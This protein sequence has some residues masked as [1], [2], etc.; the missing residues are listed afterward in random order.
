MPLLSTFGAASARSFGGIGGAAAGAGLD[1]TDAFSTFLYQGTGS[2]QSINNGI[3]LSG[4]GGLVWI[5][6]NQSRAHALFDTERGV[7]KVLITAETAAQANTANALTAFNSNGFSLGIDD[8]DLVNKNSS[9]NRMVAWTFRKA[10]KFF[11]VVTYTGN[12]SSRTISHNLGSVPGMIIIK[13]TTS[14]ED[15]VVY[16]RSLG[17]GYYSKL[18]DTAQ[19]LGVNTSVFNGTDATNSV[20]SVGTSSKSN[21]SGQ[22]YVAYVFAHNNSDGGF[23]PDSDQDIIKCGSYTGNN[24]LTGP[25]VNLGFEPQFVLLKRATSGAG[26]W[27]MMDAMRGITSGITNGDKYFQT[28]YSVSEQ[29]DNF[30]KLTANG[31]DVESTNSAI[32]NSGDTYI[33]MA[34]RRGSLAVP[35]DATKVF[36]VEIGGSSVADN[37]LATTT[38]FPVDMF[39]HYDNYSSGGETFVVDRLRGRSAQVRT[40]VTNAEGTYSTNNPSLDSNSGL[41]NRAGS[42]KNLSGGVYWQ[43]KRAL[44]YF[45]V[46]AYTGNGTAGTSIN[47]NLGVVPEMIWLRGRNAVSNWFVYHKD[48]NGGTNPEDY[49][50]RINTSGAENNATTS[51]NDTAPTASSF[52]T[53]TALSTSGNTYIAYLFATVAGVSKVGSYTG[54]GES[55]VQTIDCGFSSGARFVLI[56]KSSSTGN[57]I[58]YDAERGIST[59][60]SDGVL[61]LNSGDAESPESSFFAGNAMQPDS[62][63]FKVTTDDLNRSGN[64]YIFYAI[65]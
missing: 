43:W 50:L 47:H 1:I 63:G 9:G 16:H 14:Q 5:K 29:Q 25:S 55:V 10:S 34:I 18:Q 53:G 28:N 13:S 20:F 45:D 24:S 54:N 40:Q 11:D 17:G 22:T 19:F 23:G 37:A 48:L 27:F 15:W 21:G 52:S 60:T 59:A 33:F 30:I 7:G 35:D 4:E 6:S 65:A 62:S 2:A 58:V 46:V 41:I 51:L 44:G 61:L 38:G 36:D 42:T 64:T 3:D 39:M 57:W 26:S 8:S 49:H 31:F 32:N 56:K 12:G